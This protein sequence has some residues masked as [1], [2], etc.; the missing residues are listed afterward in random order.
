MNPIQGCKN[1]VTPQITGLPCFFARFATPV[2]ILPVNR[3]RTSGLAKM[4]K[5][6]VLSFVICTKKQIT[7]CKN[8]FTVVYYSQ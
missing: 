1:R 3:K 7:Y 5:N 4:H 6:K 2:M 8:V